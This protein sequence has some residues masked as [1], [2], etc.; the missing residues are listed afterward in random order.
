[1]IA[2]FSVSLNL[3]SMPTRR[4]SAMWGGARMARRATPRVK[5]GKRV[6]RRRS[7]ASRTT[8]RKYGVRA[9]FGRYA[10]LGAQPLR[11]YLGP[12]IDEK[13]FDQTTYIGTPLSLTQGGSCVHLD[14]IT[15]GD[16]V[17]QRDGKSWVETSVQFNLNV[18]LGTTAVA[19]S[20]L[21]ML[22]WDFQPNST[23]APLASVLTIQTPADLSFPNRDNQSRFKIIYA[24]RFEAVGGQDGSARFVDGSALQC[25]SE[26]VRFPF[27]ALC[28]STATDTLPPPNGGL[29]TSRIR[30]ALLA[31]SVGSGTTATPDGNGMRG[32]FNCR[33]N[34][35]D[36]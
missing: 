24:K 21:F 3:P 36:V 14:V 10:T 18:I 26:N 12:A 23:L 6:S 7:G 17:N 1:M 20:G 27:R 30:G 5:A 35:V 25:V 4:A 11:G 9:G 34:F 29:I 31:V 16:S 15:Q 22:V 33:I 2:N 32:I 13:Y 28:E 8:G 19:A